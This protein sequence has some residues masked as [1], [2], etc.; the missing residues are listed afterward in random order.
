M[1]Q[2]VPHLCQCWRAVTVVLFEPT[3]FNGYS[4]LRKPMLVNFDYKT[5]SLYE[6]RQAKT[7]LVPYASS[8]ALALLVRSY[9]VRQSDHQTFRDFI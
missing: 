1:N 5:V 8:E 2:H 3:H 7:G 9:H 6:M 4:Y